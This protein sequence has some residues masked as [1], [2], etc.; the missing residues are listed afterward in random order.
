MMKWL[1]QL[2]CKHKNVV[3]C[4]KV[5]PF[6][7]ISG[8]RYYLVCQKCGKVTDETFHKFK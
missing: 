8:E 2:F 6:C 3:W 5:E 7:C 4:R 1:K